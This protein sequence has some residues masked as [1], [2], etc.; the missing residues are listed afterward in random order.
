MRFNLKVFYR[1]SDC[2]GRGE[3]QIPW[4]NNTICLMN[5]LKVFPNTNITIVADNVLDETFEF[6]KSITKYKLLRASL[7]NCGSF[8]YILNL[9]LQED[10]DTIIYFVEN[11]YLHLP[12]SKEILLEGF[13]LPIDYITLYDHL[14]KYTD[15]PPVFGFGGEETRVLLTKSTHWKLVSSTCMT[16]ASKVKTL[17]ED[18]SIFRNHTKGSI[19]EDC[20]LFNALKNK[21]RK[22]INPLPGMA[23]HCVKSYLS[24]LVNWEEVAKSY[25]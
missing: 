25:A 14:D 24:P 7:G 11:D 12:F 23:T 10:D 3:D 21:S 15:Y 6:L 1:I 2:G 8:N 5:F 22:L 20:G 19:P 13:T 9:A 18:E 17:K 16:F 4:V